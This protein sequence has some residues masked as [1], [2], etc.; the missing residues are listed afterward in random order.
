MVYTLSRLEGISPP[1]TLDSFELLVFGPLMLAS[2]TYL[3]LPPKCVSPSCPVAFE[4]VL[5]HLFLPPFYRFWF[6]P[7]I[8][9]IPCLVDWAVLPTIALQWH[10]TSSFMSLE[11]FS[12]VFSNPKRWTSKPRPTPAGGFGSPHPLYIDSESDCWPPSLRSHRRH[13]GVYSH[14]LS[15]CPY[16]LNE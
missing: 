6:L 16:L 1:W 9:F 11:R 4:D 15:P 13:G 14:L 10:S 5:Y 12:S 3:L 2:P 7:S 8:P